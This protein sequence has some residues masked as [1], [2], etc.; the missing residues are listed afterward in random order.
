MGERIARRAVA[1][2]G[3][4]AQLIQADPTELPLFRLG[5]VCRGECLQFL[6]VGRV[7]ALEEKTSETVIQK[8]F[9]ELPVP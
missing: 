3:Q 4:L 6:L 8:I 9:D 1:L 7:G 5:D 2:I